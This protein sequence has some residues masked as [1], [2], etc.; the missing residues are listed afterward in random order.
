VEDAAVVVENN[1][2][3]QPWF[4]FS[5]SGRTDLIF[6]RLN[7]DSTMNLDG[8]QNARCDRG[9]FAQHNRVIEIALP[10]ADMA[11]TVDT[12]RQPS[13]GSSKRNSAGIYFRQRA[14]AP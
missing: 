3:Y 5:S 13:A 6:G 12:A 7:D 8:V 10:W 2:D 11:A 9:T 14:V 1:A 4:G